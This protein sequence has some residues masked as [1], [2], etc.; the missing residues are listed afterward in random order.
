MNKI[1]EFANVTYFTISTY[2]II[3]LGYKVPVLYKL[4]KIQSGHIDDVFLNLIYTIIEWF[5]IYQIGKFLHRDSENYKT[6]KRCSPLSPFC[7][8]HINFKN[9]LKLF[10][11]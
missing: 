9:I 5:I 11:K 2:I 6:Y 1:K 4:S 8:I 10:N 7:A 3:I